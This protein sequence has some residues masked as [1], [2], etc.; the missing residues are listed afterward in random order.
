MKWFQNRVLPQ[1][2]WRSNKSGESQIWQKSDLRKVGSRE[3]H[4]IK[5]SLVNSLCKGN[6]YIW[7][8]FT[9]C[10]DKQQGIN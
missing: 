3:E 9:L 1:V 4:S 8:F 6:I 7:A 2:I 10:K 5:S